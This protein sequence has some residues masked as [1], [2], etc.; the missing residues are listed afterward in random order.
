[1]SYGV[2]CGAI[3]MTPQADTGGS[4]ALQALS[5]ATELTGRLGRNTLALPG[6]PDIAVRIRKVLAEDAAGPERI[7]RII[8]A[9]PALAARLMRMANSAALNPDGRPVTELKAAVAR[10]GFNIVRSATIAFAM[11]QA[12][13]AGELRGLETKLDA[14]WHQSTL[15]AALCF[16]TASNVRGLN[17]N[18][19]LLSGLVHNIGKLYLLSHTHQFPELFADAATYQDIVRTWHGVLATSLLRQWEMPESIIHAVEHQDAVDRKHTGP[20]DLADVLNVACMAASLRDAPEELIGA[21]RYVP[22]LRLMGLDGQQL[23]V[24]LEAS[25]EQVRYLQT[26]LGR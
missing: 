17:P 4:I 11:S 14:L 1:M 18:E 8:S 2:T 26:E 16:V 23:L 21:L 10:L 20:T 19:A 15:V 22:A 24:I 12:N 9:E 13:N 5:L 7:G 6:Y 3:A 25:Q